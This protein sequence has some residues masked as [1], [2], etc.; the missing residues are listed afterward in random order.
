MEEAE[1]ELREALRLFPEYGEVDSPYRFLAEIHRER[2]ELEQAARALHRLGSLGETLHPIH[3]EEAGLWLEVGDT[4]AAAEALEMAVELVPF[5]LDT[6]QQLAE[7]HERL[8]DSRAEVQ[9]RRAVLALGPVD[10]AEAH[11]RLALA[12]TRAGEREEA[13]SEVLRALEIAP[14]YDPALELLLRLR[15]GIGDNEPE[16]LRSGLRFRAPGPWEA[17]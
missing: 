11:Y 14:T 8:G 6:Y 5:D 2:G 1:V 15:G 7:L 12:L 10:R 4:A 9:S 3:L 17:P 13:R 16:S